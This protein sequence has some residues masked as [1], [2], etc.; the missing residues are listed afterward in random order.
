MGPWSAI[1]GR[2]ERDKLNPENQIQRKLGQIEA[3]S[4][5]IPPPSRIRVRVRVRVSN[6]VLDLQTVD[7]K[8]SGLWK[9]EIQALLVIMFHF[10]Q[11]VTYNPLI[12]PIFIYSSHFYLIFQ[13]I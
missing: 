5:R 12:F 1:Q 2:N 10:F 6:R 3:P 4:P 13:N 9:F 8:T 11:N 7:K